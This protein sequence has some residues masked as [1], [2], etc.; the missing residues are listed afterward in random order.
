VTAAAHGGA[1]LHAD[2]VDVL[3]RWS[4]PGPGQ[5]QLRRVYLDH[6]RLHAD[7]MWRECHPDHVTASALVVSA[8]RSQVLLTLHRRLRR[9]LQTGGHCERTDAALASAARREAVE[10][11][12][13]ADLV[14][15]EAP[16]LLS[17]HPVPCGPLRPAHHLDVQYVAVAADG[18]EP[19]ASEESD[20]VR[21]F[22]VEALPAGT[23]D[24][25][26]ALVAH[27]LRR[28]TG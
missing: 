23:D 7:G 2:A 25:V 11:A 27:A 8:D 21:W 3:S 1:S 16:V 12:G 28:L 26:R 22:P 17:R 14:V 15:D 24:S 13:I 10:E 20:D 9:W 6:L 18:A 4:A 19:V 5:A